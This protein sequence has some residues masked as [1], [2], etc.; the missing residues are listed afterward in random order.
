MAD[1]HGHIQMTLVEYLRDG[2]RRPFA[3]SDCDCCTWAADWVV[4]C[5][6]VDPSAPLRSRYKTAL[7]AQRHI[8][9]AGSLLALIA[10][11]MAI[12]GLPETDNPQPGDLGIVV[13]GGGQA[14]GIR[15][16]SGW[17]C[18][19]PKGVALG[20]PI[21]LAAWSVPCRQF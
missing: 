4:A 11:H 6:G 20:H 5:C 1:H 12:A 13:V 18:K 8:S 15:T 14:L 10:D 21:M 19:G 16:R 7:G 17:A 9:R 3:W 2:A